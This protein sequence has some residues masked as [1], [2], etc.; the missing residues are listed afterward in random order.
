[1]SADVILN[2][3]K[4]FKLC[5]QAGRDADETVSR[6]SLMDYAVVL[7][8]IS[9][10]TN[11]QRVQMIQAVKCPDLGDYLCTYSHW[12]DLWEQYAMA[13][14]PE[15]ASARDNAESDRASR[16]VTADHKAGRHKTHAQGLLMGCYLCDEEEKAAS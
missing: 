6:F 1:M 15:I 3:D 5:Q 11:E 2:G 9:D 8:G 14:N 7:L 10:L 4:A 12:D 13:E 16:Q